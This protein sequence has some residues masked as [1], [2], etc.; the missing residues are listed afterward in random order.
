M[1]SGVMEREA[2]HNSRSHLFRLPSY[3]AIHVVRGLLG[4]VTLTESQDYEESEI[5]N[6]VDPLDIV[7]D[8]LREKI[9][10]ITRKRIEIEKSC[11]ERAKFENVHRLRYLRYNLLGGVCYRSKR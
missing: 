8:N 4:V 3:L 5:P 9:Q 2:T 6:E 11:G 1:I 10:H 7:T